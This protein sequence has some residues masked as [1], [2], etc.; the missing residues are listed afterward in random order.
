MFQA[1]LPK[2]SAWGKRTL[3][4]VLPESK[5]H[6]NLLKILAANLYILAQ[7]N[8]QSQ[9]AHE[10]QVSELRT[11]LNEQTRQSVEQAAQLDKVEREIEAMKRMI[12]EM[13][14]RVMDGS[15]VTLHPLAG[16]TVRLPNQASLTP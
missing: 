10:S 14:A 12:T 3:T 5:W 6:T 7:G 9:A 13:H 4:P 8:V 15:L 16:N 2:V 1:F 11:K